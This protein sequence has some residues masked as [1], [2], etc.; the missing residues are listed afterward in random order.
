MD[1]TVHAIVYPEIRIRVH[2]EEN[3]FTILQFTILQFTILQ[4]T[5]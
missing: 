2:L 1:S 4:F 5:I 3:Q